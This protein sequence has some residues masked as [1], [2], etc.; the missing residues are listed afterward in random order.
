M[1]GVIYMHIYRCQ[2]LRDSLPL[3]WCRHNMLNNL[4]CCILHCIQISFCTFTIAMGRCE[5]YILKGFPLSLVIGLHYYEHHYFVLDNLTLLIGMKDM[6]IIK[7][8]DKWSFIIMHLVEMNVLKCMKW[9]LLN[10]HW[11]YLHIYEMLLLVIEVLP[12]E[13]H[14]G[15]K[16]E[17]T[18]GW[19][20]KAFSWKRNSR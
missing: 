16:V 10:G 13:L 6:I 15:R 9:K 19:Y 3:E 7:K 11:R 1:P 12:F 4:K 20:Y 2:L 5:N 14:L 18:S 8:I 17:Q